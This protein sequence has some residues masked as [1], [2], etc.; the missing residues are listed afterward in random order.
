MAVN[1]GTGTP[2]EASDWV[3]YCN[4]PSGTRFG[5]LRAEHGREAPWD[6]K[7]W[8]LGNEMSGP[9]QVGHVP[10]EEYATRAHQ[11]AKMIQDFDPRIQLVAS[12]S[13]TNLLP[14]YLDWDRVL[15]ERL[16]GHVD[17]LSLHNYVGN[18]T[19]NHH[20]DRGRDDGTE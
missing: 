2:E 6:V 4:A 19:E 10:V 16:Q 1:L 8:C 5:D 17:Y 20:D 14:S 13:A 18:R 15:L 7:L 9:W 3:E 11:A 12:G